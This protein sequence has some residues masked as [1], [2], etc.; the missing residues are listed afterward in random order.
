MDQKLREN[1]KK[2]RKL[3]Q[4]GG[5]YVHILYSE[6]SKN[7]GGERKKKGSDMERFTSAYFI[8]FLLHSFLNH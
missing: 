2:T 8:S 7:L 6:R 4:D 1:L 3:K 5:G